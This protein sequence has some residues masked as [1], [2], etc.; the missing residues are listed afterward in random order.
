MIQTALKCTLHLPTRKD[1]SQHA[2]QWQT[3]EGVLQAY[4]IELVPPNTSHTPQAEK[5]LKIGHTDSQQSLQNHCFS[6]EKQGGLLVKK[7]GSLT[8]IPKL[9]WDFQQLTWPTLILHRSVE[10]GKAA[11]KIQI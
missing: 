8:S 2:Q 10:G 11:H 1:F 3:L 7:A 6:Y 9:T 5:V 4:F